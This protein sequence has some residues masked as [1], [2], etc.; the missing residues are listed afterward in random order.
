[1]KRLLKKSFWVIAFVA[2]SLS[3]FAQSEIV[4]KN[5]RVFDGISIELSENTEVLIVDNIITEVSPTASRSASKDA[6]IIDGGGRVLMP[7]L[8]DTHVHLAFGS[9][10]QMQTFTGDPGYNYIYQTKDGKYLSVGA[11]VA[12]SGVIR[13][14]RPR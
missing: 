11:I 5:V 13:P 2:I 14:A 1:M 6:K 9:N 4:F 12:V 7:G 10:S 8:A 3:S